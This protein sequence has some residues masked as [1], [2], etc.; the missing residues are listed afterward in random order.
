MMPKK[1][2]RQPVAHGTDPADR[3][4]MPSKH[5]QQPRVDAASRLIAA[6]P[7][8][9]FS[10]FA[11]ANALAQWLPPDSMT[12]RALEYDFREGG[13]YRIELRYPSDGAGKTSERTDVS[14]GRF[15]TIERD[16]R[17]VQSVEFDAEDPSFSGV[18][19]MTWSFEPTTTGTLVT[20]KAEAV[21]PGISAADHDAGLRSSLANLARFTERS[22]PRLDVSA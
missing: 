15:I 7:S 22:A 11:D 20:I 21:P 18:M 13:A 19:T 16:A 9:V 6:P 5:S 12:G 3:P 8:A 10:A 17:I 14:H 2:R 4:R 1:R